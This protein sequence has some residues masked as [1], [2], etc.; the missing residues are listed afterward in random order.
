MGIG[1]SAE[2]TGGQSRINRLLN[3]HPN[4]VPMTS[5][6]L[7]EQGVNPQLVARYKKSKWLRPLGHGAWIRT[8]QEVD[9]KAAI[10]TL[11]TQQGLK[12]FPA[13]K[14][15][16]E[17][18]G[19]GHFL[20]LG[21]TPPIYLSLPAGEKLPA[22]FLRQPFAANLTVFNSSALFDP[23]YAALTRWEANDFSIQISTP[24]R[25]IIELCHLLPRKADAE[26]V[27]LLMQGLTSL[28]PRLLQKTLTACQSI[29][30]KRLFLAL[31]EIAD[32][33]WFAQLDIAALHLGRGKRA[34]QIAG[35]LHPKFQITVPEVWTQT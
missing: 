17:L 20:P 30:A 12:V 33:P 4:N 31:A 9:W 35:R 8:G 7:G 23:L 24:E 6:W 22:W 3:R 2:A 1:M 28:R 25:A 18:A 34:L 21:T 11:Q 13:G 15:A 16:L 10:A 14:T 29:K 5:K 32:W 26:E 27:Y 19:R